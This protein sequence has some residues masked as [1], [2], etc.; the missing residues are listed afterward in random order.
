MVRRRHNRHDSCVVTCRDR[1]ARPGIALLSSIIRDIAADAVCAGV[2]RTYATYARA[3][4][5]SERSSH[6]THTHTYT[7]AASVTKL[8]D[9]APV[10]G[11]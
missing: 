11:H 8:Y 6:N 1:P 7:C 2:L 5:D 10:E 9:T 3:I 4:C